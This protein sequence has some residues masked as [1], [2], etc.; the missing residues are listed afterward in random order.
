MSHAPLEPTTSPHRVNWHHVLAIFVTSRL[1]LYGAALV[2]PYFFEPSVFSPG[3]AHEVNA[4]DYWS[5]WD[6]NWFNAIAQNGYSYQ[7]DE[8]SSVA[9]F[10]LLP[11]LIRTLCLVGIPAWVAGLIIANVCTLGL[12]LVFHQWI[13]HEFDSPAI[14]ETATALLAFCPQGAWFV[15]GYSEPLYLLTA[16][17]TLACARR[18]RWWT[19]CLWGIAHGLTRSNGITLALPLFCITAPTLLA[20]IRS[21]KPRDLIMPGLTTAAA[22]IGHASYLIFLWARFGTW[23]ANQITSKAGWGVSLA[24]DFHH[25]SQKIPGLGFQLFT[26]TLR[27]E[28][29]AWSWA[30]ALAATL[31]A[32]AV[33]I[34]KRLPLFWA[35]SLAA[36]WSLFLLT[37]ECDWLT[38]SMGRFAA[39]LFPVAVAQALFAEKHRWAQPAFLAFNAGASFINLA[40]VFSSYHIV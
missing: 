38:G 8:P 2:L 11:M 4:A 24:I 12:L 33:F 23:Q 40:L 18:A 27:R 39:V 34:G 29:I 35:A 15:L 1:L 5:R 6:A 30:I 10:P 37:A 25:L 16:V 9:F 19:A 26:H 14:A 22:W 3:R 21:H 32:L 20:A 31:F 7:A 17:A 36:F 28:W 13:R